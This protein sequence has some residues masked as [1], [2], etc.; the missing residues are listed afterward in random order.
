[1]PTVLRRLNQFFRRNSNEESDIEDLEIE[2]NQIPTNSPDQPR[3]RIARRLHQYHQS[4]P[5]RRR[6]I[7]H[8]ANDLDSPSDSMLSTLPIELKSTG[9]KRSA[10]GSVTL[11]V[12]LDKDQVE[13]C[14]CL[15]AMSGQIYRCRGSAN[16]RSGRSKIVCH[17]ICAKC[18]WTMRRMKEDNGKHKK[19]QCPICKIRGDFVRNRALERQLLKLSLPCKHAAVGCSQRFFPWDDTR[20]VH[21]KY[22]CPFGPVDCPFCYQSIPG[23]R[24]NFIEHLLRSTMEEPMQR[25]EAMSGDD[26]EQQNVSRNQLEQLIEMEDDSEA[27]R[28]EQPRNGMDWNSGNSGNEL[29]EEIGGLASAEYVDDDSVRS[30]PANRSAV[31]QPLPSSEEMTAEQEEKECPHEQRGQRNQDGSAM[32]SGCNGHCKVPGCSLAF[33]RAADCRDMDQ[34]GQWIIR[35]DRNEFIV[36]YALGVVVCSIAP[37]EDHPVWRMYVISINPRHQM[38]GNSRIYLQHFDYDLMRQ[39]KEKEAGAGPFASYLSQPTTSTVM[40]GMGRL[41]PS[42][43]RKRFGSYPAINPFLKKVSWTKTRKSLVS[44]IPESKEDDHDDDDEMEDVTSPMEPRPKPNALFNRR[45]S[46][47]L[48]MNSNHNDDEKMSM[49][50]NPNP[51]METEIQNEHMDQD[52]DDDD[53]DVHLESETDSD[54]EEYRP[55]LFSGRSPCSDIQCATICGGMARYGQREIQNLCIRLFAL[56][57][58]LKVGAIVDCRDFTGDWFE[59]EILAVQDSHGT[60][61]KEIENVRDECLEIRRAKV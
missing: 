13:C 48:M 27:D 10:D 18:E 28:D 43:L 9:F 1:M 19:M 41:H 6:R 31:D 38:A 15:S 55:E 57:E 56:E 4:H 7:S 3:D 58:S 36:C 11:S 8:S 25:N 49:N 21:E 34:M 45:Q 29:N 32:D 47:N 46:V 12:V 20:N 59:A 61:F 33:H 39:Y 40:I 50:T 24:T 51:E 5:Q 42:A 17:N 60:I 26:M 53:D 35:R 37:S 44:P 23:G 14:V 54:L 2:D 22:L 30:I 16:P 52:D